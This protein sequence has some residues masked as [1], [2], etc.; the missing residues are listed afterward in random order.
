[1]MLINEDLIMLDLPAKT[2]EEAINLLG[3]KAKQAGRVSDVDGYT[4]AVLA[5]E[6]QY[7]TGVGFGVAIPHG[8]TDAVTEPFLMF[9]TVKSLDWSSLD[10]KDVDLIFAIGVPEADSSTLHLKILSKLSRQL[11]KEDF[12]VNLRS[13][14][15]PQDIIQILKDSDVG[16]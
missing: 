9:A 7:S 16:I 14:K 8:K 5:R 15:T 12:R 11:M 13:A 4:K 1:M 6:E 10:G 3:Q 2:K